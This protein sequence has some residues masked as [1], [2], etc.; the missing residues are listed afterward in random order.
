LGEAGA[1]LDVQL[2][3]AEARI[4]AARAG[5]LDEIETVAAEAADDIVMR[6]A[7]VKVD[8]AAT[9]AAVKEALRG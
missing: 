7:G 9:R 1:K 6:L 3:Q 2:T 4:A 5:A 8:Q